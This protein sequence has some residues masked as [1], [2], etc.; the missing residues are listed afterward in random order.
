[1]VKSS[2]APINEVLPAGTSIL[3]E[4]VLKQ[5]SDAGKHVIVLEV[6]KI[7]HIGTVD[8]AN[9]PL[10]KTG[11]PLEFLRSYSHLRPKTTTVI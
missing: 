10:A 9:Y 5:Q 6:E 4:G 11:L 7:L 3:A 2:V 8:L 1:M